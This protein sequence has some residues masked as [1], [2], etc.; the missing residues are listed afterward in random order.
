M[1]NATS[2][3]TA[4]CRIR[5]GFFCLL[6]IP[7]VI[8][9]TVLIRSYRETGFA[10][11]L[12]F[13]RT[14]PCIFP[15]R[16]WKLS[17]RAEDARRACRRVVQLLKISSPCLVESLSLMVLFR[18]LGISHELRFGAQKIAEKISFHCWIE[19]SSLNKEN[20]SEFTEF[21]GTDNI[22][23]GTSESHA[24]TN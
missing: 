5:R 11:L 19:S 16:N 9:V 23:L 24:I 18:L 6:F 17:P 14:I 4:L 7:I 13:L 20:L 15:V 8:L 1:F 21:F 22:P 3:K 2:R 10:R 12:K